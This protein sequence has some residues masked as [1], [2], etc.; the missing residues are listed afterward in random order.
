[1][2]NTLGGVHPF[3]SNLP[4]IPSHTAGSIQMVRV[5][6]NFKVKWLLFASKTLIISSGTHPF[7]R[8]SFRSNLPI[9]LSHTAGTIEIAS[10]CFILKAKWLTLASKTLVISCGTHPF[11]HFFFRSNLPIILSHTAGSIEIVSVSFIFKCQPA[12][13]WYSHVSCAKYRHN[14]ASICQTN[15]ALSHKLIRNRHRGK[16][17]SL[18]PCQQITP[19][20]VSVMTP[21]LKAIFLLK[22]N[23]A[24]QTKFN[25]F[26]N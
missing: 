18:R 23:Q 9:I 16:A 7:Y 25:S 15:L 22:P 12:R 10:V 4:I 3:R 20:L 19:Y 13:H 17:S 6:F 21:S 14:Y 1:M 26:F 2:T 24:A 5:C 8:S 11:H